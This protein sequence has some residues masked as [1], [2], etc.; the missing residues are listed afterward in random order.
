[1]CSQAPWHPVASCDLDIHAGI[2]LCRMGGMSPGDTRRRDARESKEGRRE[3]HEQ[4]EGIDK[5]QKG[6][7]GVQGVRRSGGILDYFVM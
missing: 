1:M 6:S 2:Q 4:N 3:D 5:W 7:R